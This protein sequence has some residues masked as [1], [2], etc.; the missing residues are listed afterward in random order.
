M[1][2]KS[3]QQSMNLWPGDYFAAKL[4]SLTTSIIDATGEAQACIF[5]SPIN[6]TITAITFRFG[7]ITTGGVISAEIQSC[8]TATESPSDVIFAAGAGNSFS[9]TTTM[10]NTWQTV[11]LAT[12]CEV[13][14]NDRLAAV[15]KRADTGGAGDFAIGTLSANSLFV[16]T[17]F[18][19][20]VSWNSTTFF[21]NI[22]PT[23][24]GTAIAAVARF[25]PYFIANVALSAGADPDEV[26]NIIA[27]PFRCRT[28]SFYFCNNTTVSVGSAIKIRLYGTDGTST[29]AT[30][31]FASKSDD[32]I[33]TGYF[34]T[35]VTLEA[36]SSYRITSF[37]S[38]GATNISFLSLESVTAMGLMT[39]GSACYATSR[40]DL[41][42]W[43]DNTAGRFGIGL[44]L[45]MFDD[46][47]ASG[48]SGSGLAHIIGGGM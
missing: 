37:L 10:A 21:K 20:A 29:L 11:T 33:R 40:T 24:S 46:S 32:G 23:F 17:G 22:F 45:D 3:F 28:N 43:S 12:P 6:G 9:V 27:F 35:A 39:L 34:N 7:A 38:T 4:T 31:T 1:A 2:L 30:C 44:I 25:A 47:S 13:A 26:G 42:A 18:G 41:G 36:N 14:I 5:R 15:V 16:N 48:G 8:L 19:K